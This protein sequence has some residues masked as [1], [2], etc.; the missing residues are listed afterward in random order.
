MNLLTSLVPAACLFL[1]QTA[2]TA[3]GSAPVPQT[4]PTTATDQAT[5]TTAATTP[6]AISA[7]ALRARYASL[8]A[9]RA[10]VEQ[11][12]T[13]RFLARPLKSEVEIE[14]KDG[15]IDWRTTRPVKSSIAIDQN[16]IHMESGAAPGMGEAMAQASRDPRA[17]AFIGFLR[18]LF[19]LDFAAI[20]RD[21]E[22]TFEGRAM[23]ATPRADSSLGEMIQSIAI[24]FA[25]DLAIER[26]EV[27]TRDETTT[28]R[29]KTFV[30]GTP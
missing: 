25:A 24:D 8:T 20:E 1:A 5:Q 19:A 12:K 26:V 7:E 6:P 14:M 11:E 16:G 15:R 3:A 17:V 28:L 10:T 2:P 29:F 21:F 22:L 27:R 23:R 9:F 13:A 4:A 18:A 30:P